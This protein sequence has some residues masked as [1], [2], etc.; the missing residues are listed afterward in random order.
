MGFNKYKQFPDIT[1]VKFLTIPWDSPLTAIVEFGTRT[2]VLLA[3][4][5]V[6]TLY[7]LAGVFLTFKTCDEEEDVPISQQ[8]WCDKMWLYLSSSVRSGS[9]RSRIIDALG[10]KLAI[11]FEG[12]YDV[13]DQ[14][15]IHD[16]TQAQQHSE[17][18]PYKTKQTHSVHEED[19]FICR[20]TVFTIVHKWHNHG[21]ILTSLTLKK[22]YQNLHGKYKLLEDD[23]SEQK[24]DDYMCMAVEWAGS[25]KVLSYGF[26]LQKAE[27]IINLPHLLGTLLPPNPRYRSHL[28]RI[29]L[30]H[31]GKEITRSAGLLKTE[32]GQTCGEVLAEDEVLVIL[33]G[34]G[35]CKKL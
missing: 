10:E 21:D 32:R 4:K 16:F 27:P 20:H 7:Q 23:N 31:G 28:H 19:F 11:P 34:G 9:Q 8:A 22:L 30:G 6:K 17:Q 25:G 1:K 5:G 33:P 24:N 13:F 29:F 18:N 3:S 26:M 12:I 35:H 15:V 2:R 14:G